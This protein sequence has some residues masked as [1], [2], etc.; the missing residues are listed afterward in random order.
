[1]TGKEKSSA[2]TTGSY[3]LLNLTEGVQG[4]DVVPRIG[5]VVVV[6][7]TDVIES[8]DAFFLMADLPGF[9]KDS[10][11]VRLEKDILQLTGKRS[12]SGGDA[13]E[14]YSEGA[15]MQESFK[16]SFSLPRGIDADRVEATLKDGV[17]RVVLPKR[18]RRQRTDDP[19][20]LPTQPVSGQTPASDL[21]L[22]QLYDQLIALSRESESPSPSREQLIE[23]S[24]N[25]LRELQAKEAVA[26]HRAFEAGLRMPIDAGSQLLDQ[27]K[28]LK[29]HLEDLAAT[30]V[31]SGSQ[32]ES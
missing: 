6:P 31:P 8:D 20:S 25:R 19:R 15:H 12:L 27:A 9:D 17:L 2:G 22:D 13:V 24:L 10:I 3:Q 32:A 21:G 16:R 4:R 28:S 30:D 1:M 23:R 26:Y 14:I 29:A 7:A 11:E 5:S 18:Q